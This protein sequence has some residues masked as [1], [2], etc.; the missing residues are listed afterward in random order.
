MSEPAKQEQ[1]SG[2]KEA[3]NTKE[4]RP[5]NW[6]DVPDDRTMEGAGEKGNKRVDQMRHADNSDSVDN[7]VPDT[8]DGVVGYTDALV[9][10]ELD[11]GNRRDELL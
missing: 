8:E 4:I 7:S 3:R 5:E 6:P 11:R 1:V 2:P 10:E 9:D